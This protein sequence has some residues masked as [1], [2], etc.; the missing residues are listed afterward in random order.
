MDFED[1]LPG[2]II[3]LVICVLIIIA[4]SVFMII[5][6]WK[7][8]TKCHR[9]GWESIVPYYNT[10]I[11]CKVAG[12]KIMWAI[13]LMV[14]PLVTNIV[15]NF[16]NIATNVINNDDIVIFL[17]IGVMIFSLA[18]VVITY[19]ASFNIYLNL[20]KKFGKSTGFG[21]GLVLLPIV[22]IPILAFGKDEYQ[23]IPVNN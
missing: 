12:S 17:A 23:D 14:A 13:I 9:K 8:F 16:F 6:N 4:I 2:F 21:V 20:A 7:L 10:Y 11:L 18:V 1:F 19:I 15:S 5:A 3:L 22:F